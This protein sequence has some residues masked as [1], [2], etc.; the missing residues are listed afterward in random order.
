MALATISSVSRPGLTS[1]GTTPEYRAVF[2]RTS[3]FGLAAMIGTE[4]RALLQRRA[5]VPDSVNAMIRRAL[6]SS[7]LAAAA[8]AIALPTSPGSRQIWRW[9]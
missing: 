3:A 4:G 5:V 9:R 7:A 8:C 6:S 2:R 1:S